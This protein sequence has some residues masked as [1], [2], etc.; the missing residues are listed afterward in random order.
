MSLSECSLPLSALGTALVVTKCN[1][2]GLSGPLLLI[3]RCDTR[4]L[5]LL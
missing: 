4:T 3:P 1:L 2:R 5:N